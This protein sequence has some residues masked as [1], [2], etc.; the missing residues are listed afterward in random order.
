MK[1]LPIIALS[2]LMLAG[3]AT[4]TEDE[5]VMTEAMAPPSQEEVCAK[6]DDDGTC[7]CKVMNAAGQ[8]EQGGGTV[9]I[10]GGNNVD[11]TDSG[12]SDDGAPEPRR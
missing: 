3:C 4:A 11:G 5:E 9:I 7:I 10:Q 2:A 12:D 8:C 6:R 1:I